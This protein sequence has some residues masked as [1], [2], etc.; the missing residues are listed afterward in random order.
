VVRGDFAEVGDDGRIDGVRLGQ[1]VHGPG[2][3]AH[4]PGIDDDG[5]ESFGQ[6]GADRRLLVRAGGFEDDPPGVVGPDPVAQ[7]GDAGGRV[8]EPPLLVG[9]ADVDVEVV[10]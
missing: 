4:L 2:E 1:V 7:L 6:Q 9:G 5:G 8:G 3:V 10:F